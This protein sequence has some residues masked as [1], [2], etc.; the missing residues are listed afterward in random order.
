MPV[1]GT[2][3]LVRDVSELTGDIRFNI[4]TSTVRDGERVEDLVTIV[5]IERE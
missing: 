2:I 4:I 1:P 3:E 5:G